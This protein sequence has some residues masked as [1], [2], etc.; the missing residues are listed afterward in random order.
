VH[1]WTTATTTSAARARTGKTTTRR[2]AQPQARARTEGD[3]GA[4][5]IWGGTDLDAC[6]V[7]LPPDAF[8][9]YIVD[10]IL[11][12]HFDVGGYEVNRSNCGLTNSA[13]CMGGQTN[14]AG[15]MGRVRGRGDLGPV[16]TC[17]DRVIRG[18]PRSTSKS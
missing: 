8:R 9:S 4:L 6:A 14:S 18:Y 17:Y 13:G 7:T 1:T 11:R 2:R 15:C 12:Q 10:V 3:R 5:L 16:R